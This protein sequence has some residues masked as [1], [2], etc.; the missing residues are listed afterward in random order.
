MSGIGRRNDERSQGE[1]GTYMNFVFRLTKPH[2]HVVS[3]VC[4][5]LVVVWFIAI[6]ATHDLLTLIQDII[7]VILFW[8]LAVRAE[9]ILEEL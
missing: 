2:A 6:L 4:S 9:E 1:D 5:N 3:S 7:F 8:Y